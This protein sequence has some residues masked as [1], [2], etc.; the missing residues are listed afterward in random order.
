MSYM[1]WCIGEAGGV[2]SGRVGDER[3]RGC[4][5]GGCS[6][7]SDCMVGGGGVCGGGGLGG[8][9]TGDARSGWTGKLFVLCTPGACG[10][11]IFVWCRRVQYMGDGED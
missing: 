5:D 6:G 1:V 10:R 7:A 4:E 2:Y 9:S 8:N 11:V 3:H